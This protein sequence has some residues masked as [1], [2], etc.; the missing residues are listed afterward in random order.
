MNTRNMWIAALSG[1]VLTTFVTNAPYLGLINCIACAGFWGGGVFA[2]WLY[3]RL[4]APLL[5]RQAIRLGLLTGVLA[6]V[7]GFALSFAGLAGLQGLMSD[8]GNLLPADATQ[9]ME[10]LPAW[11]AIV[12]NLVGVVFTI[13]F[14]GLG[15]W[16][17]A[18]IFNRNR[19]PVAE[20]GT[21]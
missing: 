11:A 19:K 18:A 6:G 3:Q 10:N 8:T 16:I 1:A 14:G 17:G 15:G 12:F 2:V 5:M 21:S 9:E 20:V 4:S 7:L 13:V